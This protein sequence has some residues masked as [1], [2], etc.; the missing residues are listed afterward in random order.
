V[1][2]L[3]QDLRRGT[4]LEAR[5]VGP[6]TGDVPLQ[7]GLGDPLEDT[8]ALEHTELV[9]D[10]MAGQVLYSHDIQPALLVRKGQLIVVM[11]TGVPGLTITARLEAL[12]D[13]RLGETIRLRNRDSGR[14]VSGVVNGPN[15]ARLP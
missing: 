6:S 10:K 15:A 5:H 11:T 13:G 8:S 9:R 3:R 7:R 4:L 14:I 2:T 1:L 12:Q